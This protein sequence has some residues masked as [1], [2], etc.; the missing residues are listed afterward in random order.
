MNYSVLLF[1]VL[2][3]IIFVVL[4]SFAGIKTGIIAAVLFAI[5]ELAYTVVVYKHID[6]ITIFTLAFI[7]IFACI[8][9]YTE[10]SIY[11][12]LQPVFLGIFFGITLLAMQLLDKP[13]LLIL[14]KKY[15]Y[16]M[17]ADTQQ[18]MMHPAIQEK[19]K[20]LSHILGWGFVAHAGAVAYAAF[21]MS[22]W[23]WLA[24][25]GVGLYVMMGICVLVNR[26]A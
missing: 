17:P 23:W 15:R 10:D 7:I 24:I 26:S 1:G 14:A 22:N 4:D 3:L 8:T 21:N 20:H 11:F 19:L 25:R 12:K 5:A 2:P 18:L 13:L 6:K 9:F 16:L